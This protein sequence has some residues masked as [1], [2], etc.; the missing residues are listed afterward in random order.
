MSRSRSV[1]QFVQSRI[2]NFLGSRLRS[3]VSTWLT[4]AS[5]IVVTVAPAPADQGLP[6]SPARCAVSLFKGLPIGTNKGASKPRAAGLPSASSEKRS[7][8]ASRS[9]PVSSVT[10]VRIAQPMFFGDPTSMT[11][12]TISGE[13]MTNQFLFM[14]RKEVSG[15]YS[16]STYCPLCLTSALVG[17]E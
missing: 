14:I 2:A 8:N 1:G 13:G 10:P 12:T 6:F 15:E 17:E 16:A 11:A 5:P 4:T 9:W 7:M 3:P